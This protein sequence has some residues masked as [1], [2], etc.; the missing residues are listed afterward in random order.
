MQDS[1]LYERPLAHGP[2]VRI[3]RTS[4]AGHTPVTAVLEIERRA[5]TVRAARGIPPALLRCEAGSETE[6]LSLL[7]PNAR[8]DAA[9]ARLMRDR[10]LR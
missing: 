2:V 1:L 3:R 10:G 5:G 8:D 7:E 6:A 4:E 9:I